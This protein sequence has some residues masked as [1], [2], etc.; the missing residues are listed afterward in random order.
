MSCSYSRYLWEIHLGT[1]RER[2]H[3]GAPVFPGVGGPG[4]LTSGG[5]AHI[6]LTP[7]V[8]VSPVN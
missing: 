2:D 1:P 7:G 5:S 4:S 6:Y 3:P 8:K